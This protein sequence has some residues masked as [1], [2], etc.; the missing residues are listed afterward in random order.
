[1]SKSEKYRED[2]NE[3][4]KSLDDTF[5]PTFQK[6]LKICI[7]LYQAAINEANN[8]N[9]LSSAYKNITNPLFDLVK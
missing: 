1:M 2:G 8:D 5:S 3:I 6:R 4:Y 7:Q 9:E